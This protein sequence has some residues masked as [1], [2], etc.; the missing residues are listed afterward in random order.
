M[1]EGAIRNMTKRSIIHGLV[2]RHTAGHCEMFIQRDDS[3]DIIRG[4]IR[5]NIIDVGENNGNIIM[6]MEQALK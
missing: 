4:I 6:F 3:G 5:W 1:P 2:S